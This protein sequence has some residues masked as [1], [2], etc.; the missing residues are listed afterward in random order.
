MTP[1][2]HS[3][4]PATYIMATIITIV[5]L[6]LW[7]FL[8]WHLLTKSGYRGLSRVTMLFAMVC[9]PVIG[10]VLYVATPWPLEKRLDKLAQRLDEIERSVRCSPVTGNVEAELN[11]LKGEMGLTK[12]KD[13]RRTPW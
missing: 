11:R 9:F 12:M 7:A 1:D 13:P 6:L 10:F 3:S 4:D 2:Y 8:W 5:V